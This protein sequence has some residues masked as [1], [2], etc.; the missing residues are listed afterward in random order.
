LTLII[1]VILLASLHRPIAVLA[2]WLIVLT[3]LSFAALGG[4]GL[5]MLAAERVQEHEPRLSAYASLMRG[6]ALVVVPGLLPVFGWF[7]VGPAL[8]LIGV[9]AGTKALRSPAPPLV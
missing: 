2:A 4:T 9:G 8:L 5:A 6:A 7:L 1:A 3:L